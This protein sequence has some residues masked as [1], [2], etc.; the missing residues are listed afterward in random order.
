M[1][2]QFAFWTPGHAPVDGRGVF[3]CASHGFAAPGLWIDP[4]AA[5][6]AT[7]PVVLE[8]E[9]VAGRYG[10]V[11]M[12]ISRQGT[13]PRA[14]IMLFAH[15]EG[16]EDFL[17][18]W[19]K[20][21]P[22]VP[23]AGGAA[24]RAAGNARGE[25]HPAAADAAV[26]LIKEG[27]WRAE[28]LNLHDELGPEVEFEAHGPRTIMRLRR[29]GDPLWQ[30]A[31]AFFHSCQ[32]DS[33]R[34]EG[35]CESITFADDGGRNLHCSVTGKHLRTGADLPGNGRLRLRT[36]TPERVAASLEAFCSQPQ[37]L[38]FG[39]AGLRSLLHAPVQVG[40]RVLAG[41]MFGEL[42]TLKARPQFA[43]LMGSRLTQVGLPQPA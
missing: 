7:W 18:Q 8:G 14:A 11:L 42:V 35:D 36:I 5:D 23:A 17:R 10:D 37:T 43:N 2:W 40:N 4:A 20:L 24:A 13:E 26:L 31:T 12:E 30:P 15:A 1:R 41:F 33:G 29:L 19:N 32:S 34:A 16:T 38:V 3:G 22:N 25:L 39:C 9:V 6:S 28:S 27:T 21:L